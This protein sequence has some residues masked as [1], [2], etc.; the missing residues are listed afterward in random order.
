[1]KIVI[2]YTLFNK[3]YHIISF[4]NHSPFL[5]SSDIYYIIAYSQLTTNSDSNPLIFQ[6]TWGTIFSVYLRILSV[7]L[8]LID[9]FY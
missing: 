1:M 9:N 2:L 6:F 8:N 5:T 3:S 4:H 7:L